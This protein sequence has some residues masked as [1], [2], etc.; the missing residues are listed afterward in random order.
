MSIQAGQ[1][2]PHRKFFNYLAFVG[3]NFHA[4]ANN[5]IE[6]SNGVVPNDGN[7]GAASTPPVKGAKGAKAV[8]GKPQPPQNHADKAGVLGA[9][10]S[11]LH[12]IALVVLTVEGV[13]GASTAL[14]GMTGDQKYHIFLALIGVLALVVVLV[15]AAALIRPAGLSPEMAQSL[16][17]VQNETEELQGFINGVVFRDAVTDII[18][19]S[20]QSTE[21]VRLAITHV[22]EDNVIPAS[23]VERSEQVRRRQID[24][25]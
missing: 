8:S 12:V 1:S 6:D 11:P 2:W 17:R 9:V 19:E 24:G 5:V 3:V 18:L 14:S 21:V 4:M 10:R 20:V 13:L 7:A 22:I 16:A 15:L 25:R 23:L